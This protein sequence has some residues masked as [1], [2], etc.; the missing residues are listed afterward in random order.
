MYLRIE[1]IGEALHE[2]FP[3]SLV[4]GDKT[5]EPGEFRMVVPFDFLVGLRVEGLRSL[6]F[7]REHPAKCW[8]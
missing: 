8:E 7:N 6:M 2:C 4:F 1:R 3:A 5:P